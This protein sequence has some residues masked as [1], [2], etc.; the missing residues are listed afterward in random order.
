[1]AWSTITPKIEVVCY[2]CSES[3]AVKSVE[4]DNYGTVTL[5]VPPCDSCIKKAESDGKAEA[6]HDAEHQI[7]DI[8][9]D[10]KVA[11]TQAKDEE[12]ETG[13]VDGRNDHHR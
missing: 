8:E 4:C 7:E 12:Y 6:E 1:M 13:F 11:M 10:H 3:L 9:H 2:L 5:N